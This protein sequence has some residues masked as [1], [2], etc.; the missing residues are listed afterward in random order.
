MQEI[1]LLKNQF[2]IKSPIFVLVSSEIPESP[3]QVSDLRTFRRPT[4]DSPGRR[5]PA[6][7][8]LSQFSQLKYI[9]PENSY[10]SWL[11]YSFIVLIDRFNKPSTFRKI[12]F[13]FMICEVYTIHVHY[14]ETQI[15]K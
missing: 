15:K 10:E 6:G 13:C 8:L 11:F 1:L 2:S 12:I 7:W 3:L 4:G 14:Q 9:S 5:V